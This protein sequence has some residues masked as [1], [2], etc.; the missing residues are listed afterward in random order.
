MFFEDKQGNETIW[1]KEIELYGDSVFFKNVLEMIKF[2][3]EH[4]D[5]I[6]ELEKEVGHSAC[7][8]KEVV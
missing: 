2:Y 1:G 6:L 4:K 3:E 7:Q 5:E 8:D